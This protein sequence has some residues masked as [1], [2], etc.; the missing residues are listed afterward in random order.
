MKNNQILQIN[1]FE[2][3]VEL[4]ESEQ[5]D[6]DQVT[7]LLNSGLKVWFPELPREELVQILKEWWE[8]YGH[9]KEKPLFLD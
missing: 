3:L 8:K 9:Q 2:E 6:D 1:S 4:I 7:T 5:L